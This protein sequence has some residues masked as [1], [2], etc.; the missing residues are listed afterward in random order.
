MDISFLDSQRLHHIHFPKDY[1]TR[2]IILHSSYTH[3]I[4]NTTPPQ[5]KK[6][7]LKYASCLT[8]RNFPFPK[9]FYS[10]SLIYTRNY[11][12][13]GLRGALLPPGSISSKLSLLLA[14]SLIIS[15]ES[16]QCQLSRSPSYGP[17]LRPTRMPLDPSKKIF[18]HRVLHLVQ[19]HHQVS[20]SPVNPLWHSL[21]HPSSSDRLLLYAL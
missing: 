10:V 15:S 4:S 9:N 7:N 3:K 21:H 14:S 2:C 1:K 19:V 20:Q 5:K 18:S 6:K 8:K 12:W 11:D 17:N 16:P 13:L